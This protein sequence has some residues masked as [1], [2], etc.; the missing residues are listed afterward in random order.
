[1]GI[2]GT[3]ISTVGYLTNSET[4]KYIGGLTATALPNT[5]MFI[6]DGIATSVVHTTTAAFFDSE[7][8][9]LDWRNIGVTGYYFTTPSA[10]L[11]YDNQIKKLGTDLKDAVAL[12][13]PEAAINAAVAAKTSLETL[14]T[15]IQ[16][17]NTIILPS[18][19]WGSESKNPT[20]LD[21]IKTVDGKDIADTT[22]RD[23]LVA[24]IDGPLIQYGNT[25]VFKTA[26]LI[27][28]IGTTKT[29]VEASIQAN[30]VAQTLTRLETITEAVNTKL[31]G[32][33]AYSQHVN[34]QL[35]LTL[36]PTWTAFKDAQ[37]AAITQEINEI[38][39][40]DL[41][42]LSLQELD[43][44]ETQ[45]NIRIQW[46]ERI[47]KLEG[48][49]LNA[50]APAEKHSS[51]I[52]PFISAAY[53]DE[54]PRKSD[55]QKLLERLKGTSNPGAPA[56]GQPAAN[57]F[58]LEKQ[59]RIEAFSQAQATQELNTIGT[60]TRPEDAKARLELLEKSIAGSKVLTDDE[61]KDFASRVSTLMAAKTQEITDAHVKAATK[62]W[63]TFKP[64]ELVRD[65]AQESLSIKAPERESALAAYLRTLTKTADDY[66]TNSQKLAQ[67]EAEI[68]KDASLK[69]ELAA[70]LASAK[71][72]LEHNPGKVAYDAIQKRKADDAAA[73]GKRSQEAF[74]SKS[75]DIFGR[76]ANEFGMGDIND[77]VVS[78]GQ[79]LYGGGQHIMKNAAPVL[80]DMSEENGTFGKTGATILKIALVALAGRVSY[81]IFSQMFGQ[82][83]TTVGISALAGLG[84][85]ALLASN[86]IIHNPFNGP[87]PRSK[88]QLDFGNASG[89]P[90][91]QSA[92]EGPKDTDIAALQTGSAAEG[93]ITRASFVPTSFV[94]TGQAIA[95]GTHTGTLPV[96]LTRT[97]D[98][99]LADAKA[100]LIPAASQQVG[101]QSNNGFSNIKLCGTHAVMCGDDTKGAQYLPAEL[102]HAM[103]GENAAATMGLPAPDKSYKTFV[104]EWAPEA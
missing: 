81:S 27:T 6:G 31:Q 48:S 100:L 70:G 73:E 95:T 52:G 61:R 54:A 38:D 85:W 40:A 71:T 89:T 11:L 24:A 77:T 18:G 50:P 84:I 82:T 44:F 94:G 58:S 21:K 41:S 22:T 1:M 78:G 28:E 69:A 60:I 63:K 15:D 83:W 104:Q 2:I 8:D 3:E 47:V 75:K 19:Y 4:W 92:L 51:L 43:Q 59:R 72:A 33:E 102:T 45:R 42:T 12:T 56:T 80:K 23:G 14:K 25:P 30:D 76:V 46:L 68:A 53:A 99:E 10:T 9:I 7:R 20:E 91:K 17:G 32:S 67:I 64:G 34:R 13:D 49:A 88:L 101:A 37:V 87:A 93:S 39:A 5:A 66:T 55:A 96:H 16:N 90:G 29:A 97:T 26:A 62:F 86:N 103:A 36:G 98:G 79:F 65:D 74:E 57:A 35:A